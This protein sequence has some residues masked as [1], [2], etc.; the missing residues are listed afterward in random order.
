MLIFSKICK[1]AVDRIIAKEVSVRKS[2]IDCEIS[3]YQLKIDHETSI[4]NSAFENRVKDYEVKVTELK[5]NEIGLVK[6]YDTKLKDLDILKSRVEIELKELE[7]IRI[8]SETEQ[9]RLW[10]RLDILRDNLNTEDVWIKLWEMAYSKAIDAVWIIQQKEALHLVELA[11]QRAYLKSKQEFEEDL[12]R[13]MDYFIQMN[14][15]NDAI[16]FVKVLALKK[17]IEDIRLSAERLKNATQVDKCSA[18]LETIG[19]LL[20][21][22]V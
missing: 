10:E 3:A 21:G 15:V 6:A 13:R 11:E 18:Q 22:S 8:K 4:L 9:K 12:N 1:K 19:G 2:E 16:P 7:R 14:N 5:D 20:N 17:R